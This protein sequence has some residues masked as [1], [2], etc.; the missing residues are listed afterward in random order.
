MPLEITESS[1]SQSQST[2][3]MAGLLSMGSV[4]SRRCLAGAAGVRAF[5]MSTLGGLPPNGFRGADGLKETTGLT[6]ISV[7]HGARAEL[8]GADLGQTR[9]GGMGGLTPACALPVCPALSRAALM[10]SL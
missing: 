10:L 1:Q 3:K 8:I 5:A 2:T 9:G 6:G 7:S 4:A